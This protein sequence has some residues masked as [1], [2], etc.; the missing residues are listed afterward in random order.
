[1]LLTAAMAA[2]CTANPGSRASLAPK[3]ITVLEMERTT[4]L[5][6][7]GDIASPSCCK[8]EYGRQ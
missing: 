1:M 8:F 2:G 6:K 4:L 3:S 5:L 7:K